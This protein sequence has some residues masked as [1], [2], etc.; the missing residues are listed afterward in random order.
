MFEGLRDC[1]RNDWELIEITYTTFGMVGEVELPNVSLNNRTIR[2]LYS[3]NIITDSEATQ[4]ELET[5]VSMADTTILQ[6]SNV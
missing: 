4:L 5:K 2:N 6:S 3:D 1:N